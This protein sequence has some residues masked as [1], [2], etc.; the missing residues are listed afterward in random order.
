MK[1]VRL[2]NLIL[3]RHNALTMNESLPG[4]DSFDVFDLSP[5]LFHHFVDQSRDPLFLLLL[6]SA[7]QLLVLVHLNRLQ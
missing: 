7:V 5:L 6:A 1:I 3:K 2:L 4:H